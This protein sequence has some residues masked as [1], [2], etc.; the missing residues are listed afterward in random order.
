MVVLDSQIILLA[1]LSLILNS[2]SHNFKTTSTDLQFLEH[3]NMHLFA[4][5][6]IPAA[7]IIPA[8]KAVDV[9]AQFGSFLTS[10]TFPEMASYRKF[11]EDIYYRMSWIAIS[12]GNTVVAT[13]RKWHSH[14]KGISSVVSVARASIS[15][16]S[17]SVRSSV[18]AI[19]KSGE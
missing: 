12:T 9:A 15:R 4:I 19:K 6:A 11:I 3:F 8:Y 1:I 13:L 18:V 16:V 14:V 5:F 2:V 10:I 17:S 7:Q